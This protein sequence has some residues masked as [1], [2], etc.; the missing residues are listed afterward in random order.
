MDLVRRT[1]RSCATLTALACAPPLLGCR[2]P[3][4]PAP[5]TGERDITIGKELPIDSAILG[6]AR[7]VSVFLP[8]SYAEGRE[9]YPVLYLIDGGPEQDFLPVAGFAAL[10]GLSA[11]YREFIVVGDATLDRRYERTTPSTVPY[12]LEQIRKNGGADDFR[13]FITEEVQPLID[14]R[15]RTSPERAVLGESLAG[16]FI[17]DTFLRAPESFDAYIA[18]SPSL[19]W[20]EAELARTAS[21]RLESD[22]PADKTLYLA[23]AD[24][25]DIIAAIAPLVAALEAHAGP[26]LR[27][28]YE[29]MPDEHHHTVYHPATL[30]A[31]RRI[32][33]PG[34]R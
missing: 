20:R 27:W 25:T 23:S 4:P 18:I 8:W 9:R 3:A 33:D 28:W 16:L 30:R 2:P 11:Q 34:R 5:L 14:S 15:Y 13:R 1:L 32:F 6:E 24:E 29:P 22:F 19:W 7:S 31:L 12:D 26:A 21:A 10:A 17:V